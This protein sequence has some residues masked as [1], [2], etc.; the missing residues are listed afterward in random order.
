[1]RNRQWIAW[2]AVAWVALTPCAAATPPDDDAPGAVL[3]RFQAAYR[4][5]SVEG[6]LA[7][8]AA[9]ATF[10]DVNQRHRF[11]GTEQLRALLS[12][13]VAM[14]LSLGLEEDRRVID[15]GTVVVEYAYKGQLNGAAL[16]ASAGKEGCPDLTY[17]MAA[18][19]WFEVEDGR[20]VNQKDF[21]DWA[22]FLALRQELLAA[23][24]DAGS[25]AGS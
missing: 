22:T 24:T 18:T 20:I 9:D 7:L 10:E 2:V 21:I 12:G 6:M 15:G 3:D 13:I 8:Y 23:G 25:D 17:T 14:H 4:A 11:Q 5:S 19:S 1:M 16:G